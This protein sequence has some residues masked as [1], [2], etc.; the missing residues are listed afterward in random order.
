MSNQFQHLLSPFK[1][2]KTEIKNRLCVAPMGDGYLGLGGPF[3]EY[4]DVGIQHIVERAKGG[5]GAFFAGCT[6]FPDNKVD[7][8]DPN[9]AVL[10]H[11]A[12]FM[13]QGL[14][15]NE[16]C[17]FFGM[18]VFQQVTMGWGRNYGMYS[19]SP[20]PAFYDPSATSPELSKEQIRQKI[21]CMVEF[22][23]LCKSSGFAGVEI[24]ALH[25]GYL[26]DNFAMA[27]TN[28]REDEY[29][30]SLE[31]R[32]RVCREIVE[33]IK[34]V[35]GQDYPVTMRLGLKS[36]IKGFNRSS[37][38]GEDEAGRTLEEG[39]RIAKLL[40][41]YG[42]DAMS[43]DVGIYDSF[44]YACQP[45]YMG[46]GQIIPL[47]EACKRELSIP[48][49]ACS[50]MNDPRVNENAVKRGQCDAVVIGRQSLADPD[51]PKKLEMGQP[52]DIRPCIG[53]NVGCIGNLHRGAPVSCAVN[54]ISRKETT[55]ALTRV[56]TPKKVAVVGGGLGGMEV[57]VDARLRG[58]DV[59]IYEKTDRL[60][61]LLI[62][63]SAHHFKKD[64]QKLIAWYQ[65][66][67]EKLGIPV[68]YNT[69]MTA[70]K[71]IAC[72]PDAAVI[73]VGSQPVVPRIDGADHPKCVTG[74]DVLNGKVWLGQEIVIVG[75]GLVGCET[76]IDY[77]S[78]GKKVTIVEAADDVLAAS[79]MIDITISMLV[80]DML[81]DNHVKLMTGYKIQ[82]V[83]D[84]GAV[85]VP[86]AGGDPVEVAADNVILSIGMR[87]VKDELSQK[88]A[89]EGIELYRTGDCA[90]VG[91]VYTVVHGAYEVARAL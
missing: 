75:G 88:L 84:K 45:T 82:G 51:Y 64:L 40:E 27:L 87:P 10:N 34:Q 41:Q 3:A 5:W 4:S 57:A 30:G 13:K 20:N 86:T 17:D 70:E 77:A 38:H 12:Y 1:I 49:L 60:G 72:K 46:N 73:A 58:H 44:Y 83:N 25:W 11:P 91:N 28:H 8:F 69:E 52:E 37:L 36:Y 79:A 56:L 15:L 43:V 62:P 78:Q 16:R 63:A 81:E 85:V 19:S 33:G 14:L 31:N 55:T 89:G 9:Y 59:T 42:Y 50:R 47:A 76:A 71:L 32:L 66:Q 90:R 24:H 65:H 68:E 61:G 35:C 22:A 7:P 48:V 74:V 23:Q 29:G 21:D 53:C 2:G 80:K 39:V 6:M 67:I 26:L 18:K 54:P